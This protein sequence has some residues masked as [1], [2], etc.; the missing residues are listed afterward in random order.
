MELKTKRLILRE[1]NNKDLTKLVKLA[2]NLNVSQYL[3]KMPYPYAEKDGKWFINKCKKDSKKEPRENYGLVIE[4]EGNL[5]G[6]IG[7]GEVDDFHGTATL[8]YWLGEEFW[9]NGIMFESVVEIIRFAFEDLNLRRIDVEAYTGNDGSNGLIK[10]L[11]FEYEGMRK[12]YKRTK[13]T[14]KIVDTNIYGLLKEDW[15][16]GR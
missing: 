11:G 14:G 4:Y 7:L 1:L 16:K 10:K 3:E 12:Q 9:R 8:G 5:V 2:N 13:S 15:V 6:I